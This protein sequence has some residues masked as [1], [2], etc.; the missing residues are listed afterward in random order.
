MPSYLLISPKP[1]SN[2]HESLEMDVEVACTDAVKSMSVKAEFLCETRKTP[3]EFLRF[4][5][6]FAS[7]LGTEQCKGERAGLACVFQVN[8]WNLFGT[9]DRRWLMAYRLRYS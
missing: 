6:F 8:V 9:P 5:Q 1:G 2:L 7:G 3:I 4:L